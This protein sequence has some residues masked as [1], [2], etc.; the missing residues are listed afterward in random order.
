MCGSTLYDCSATTSR[1][2]GQVQVKPR[3]DLGRNR[4]RQQVLELEL[5]LKVSFICKSVHYVVS[6]VQDVADRGYR[7]GIQSV[8][9]NATWRSWF[10][11]TAWQ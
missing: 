10:T 6:V 3:Q 5:K 9:S 7:T 8:K 2:V 4:C 1:C 11:M